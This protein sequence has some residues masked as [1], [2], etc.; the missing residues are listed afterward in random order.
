MP[1]AALISAYLKDPPPG[2]VLVFDCSRWEFDGDDKAKIQRV[3][4]FYSMVGSS[5]EFARHSLR[6]RREKQP[7]DL[8]VRGV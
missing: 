1:G 2:V 3:E 7:K 6:L 5:V 4:K 8:R